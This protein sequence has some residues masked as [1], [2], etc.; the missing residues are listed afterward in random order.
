MKILKYI[1]LLTIALFITAQGM[2]LSQI[3]FGSGH[4]DSKLDWAS[5]CHSHK[6]NDND[7]DSHSA[8]FGH[9]DSGCIDIFVTSIAGSQTSCST[10]DLFNK[11]KPVIIKISASSHPFSPVDYS[12]HKPALSPFYAD[13]TSLS[14]ASTILII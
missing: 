4:S 7:Y 9:T 3:C 13:I 11:A 1:F 10:D 5:N 2:T 6:N 12:K 14:I 8:A